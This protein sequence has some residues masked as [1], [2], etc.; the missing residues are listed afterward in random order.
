MKPISFLAALCAVAVSTSALAQTAAPQPPAPDTMRRSELE[1][2][3]TRLRAITQGGA[4]I[5]RRPPGCTSPESRWLDFWLGEWDVAPNATSANILA[6]STISLHDQGCVII[7]EWRPLRSGHG[8]S[9]NGYDAR[10]GKWHQTW[11]DSTGGRAEYA[12]TFHDGALYLD[13]IGPLPPGTPADARLRMNYRAIDANT[14]RQ[15]GEQ[16][17]PATNAW[18]TTWEFYYHR[19]SGPMTARD[20]RFAVS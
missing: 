14:V 19:R 15:W 9:I 20:L 6:E 8:H 13:N 3:V 5:P 16:F 4:V 11:I 12:G 10:D 18:T 1:E 7:E 2:E 17:D